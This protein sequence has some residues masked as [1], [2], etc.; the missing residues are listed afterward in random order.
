MSRMIVEHQMAPAAFAFLVHLAILGALGDNTFTC[1]NSIS[2]NEAV[3]GTDS[4]AVCFLVEHQM[5]PAA[6]AFL[7]HLAI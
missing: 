3:I 7:V 2:Y 5:A 4:G 1:V 6:F